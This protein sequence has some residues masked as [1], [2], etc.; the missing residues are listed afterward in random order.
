MLCGVGRSF[1]QK[2]EGEYPEIIAESYRRI[3]QGFKVAGDS[4]YAADGE[5][6]PPQTMLSL[7][8]EEAKEWIPRFSSELLIK[9]LFDLKLKKYFV[10]REKKNLERRKSND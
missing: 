7:W 3:S 10:Y 5:L 6:F 4:Y 2:F 8:E 1:R 9:I